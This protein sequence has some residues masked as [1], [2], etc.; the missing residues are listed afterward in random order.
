MVIATLPLPVPAAP[1]VIEIHETAEVA[2]HE[3][4]AAVVTATV[5]VPPG[6]PTD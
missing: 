3:H 1:A 2:D 4:V 6:T 5:A